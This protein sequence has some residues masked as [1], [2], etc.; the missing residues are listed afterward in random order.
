M[1]LGAH[2][3]EEMDCNAPAELCAHNHRCVFPGHHLI[4]MKGR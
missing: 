4:G 1:K 2:E 3:T